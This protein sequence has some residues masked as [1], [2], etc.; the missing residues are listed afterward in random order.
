M[1]AAVRDDAERRRPTGTPGLALWT[2]EDLDTTPYPLL[3]W[4]GLL[5]AV[6][7]LL[8]LARLMSKIASSDTA[9]ASR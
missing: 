2:L 7:W 5:V 9:P 6:A 1:A 8:L 3:G 4:P